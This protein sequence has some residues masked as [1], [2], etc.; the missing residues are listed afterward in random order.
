MPPG[1]EGPPAS[2]EEPWHPPLK[3]PDPDG[4][5]C[6]GDNGGNLAPGADAGEGEGFFETVLEHLQAG[7]ELV[8]RAL[9][10]LAEQAGQFNWAGFIAALYVSKMDSSDAQFGY[11]FVDPQGWNRGGHAAIQVVVN[12]G[13]TVLYYDVN[14]PSKA[15]ATAHLYSAS[16]FQST[17]GARGYHVVP[18]NV[19]DA[20]AAL[21]YLHSWIGVSW[22]YYYTGPNCATYATGAIEAG[23]GWVF[24][25]GSWGE[26]PRVSPRDAFQGFIS[27]RHGL[28][29]ITPLL[30][31]GFRPSWFRVP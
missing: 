2:G 14:G 7:V 12:D 15:S 6:V 9:E 23:G 17:Y 10:Q 3:W 20:A 31:S 16:S 27:P 21:D 24:D 11:V 1:F 30:G 18:V 29:P 25:N 13:N 26:I 8:E 28:V 22:P 5:D 19:P 4:D